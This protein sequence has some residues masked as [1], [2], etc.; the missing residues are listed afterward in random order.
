MQEMTSKPRILGPNHVDTD[1]DA[2]WEQFMGDQIVAEFVELTRFYGEETL[3]EAV[4]GAVRSIASDD[5]DLT[6]TEIENA[7]A[8]CMAV[9]EEAQR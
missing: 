7:I 1:I 6:E 8:C 3:A 9:I 5:E 4:D 2:V